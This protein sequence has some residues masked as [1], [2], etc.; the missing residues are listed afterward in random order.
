MVVAGLMMLEPIL[1]Q[2]SSSTIQNPFVEPSL[3][4]NS[5]HPF[6]DVELCGYC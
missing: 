6:F 5:F 2:F 1:G 3:N 4:S